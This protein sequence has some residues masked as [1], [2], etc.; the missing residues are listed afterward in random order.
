[1]VGAGIHHRTTDYQPMCCGYDSD[2]GSSR[3]AGMKSLAEMVG[4]FEAVNHDCE[5][6]VVLFNRHLN[7]YL[8][9]KDQTKEHK[10]TCVVIDLETRQ[11]TK[12]M[13]VDGNWNR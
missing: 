11:Q 10:V 9:P 13:I 1:M 12:T 8:R 7:L 6:E 3:V 2:E 5:V 4:K